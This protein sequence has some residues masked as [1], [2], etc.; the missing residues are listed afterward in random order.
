MTRTKI[1]I[2]FVLSSMLDTQGKNKYRSSL[3]ISQNMNKFTLIPKKFYPTNFFH[4]SLYTLHPLD[5]WQNFPEFSNSVNLW[6][7]CFTVIQ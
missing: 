2:K 4:N 6:F 3:H 7:Q 5:I 1:V